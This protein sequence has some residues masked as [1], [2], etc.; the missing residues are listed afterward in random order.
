MLRCFVYCLTWLFQSTLHTHK[1][2]NVFHCWRFT[3]FFIK[4]HRQSLHFLTHERFAFCSANSIF[5]IFQPGIEYIFHTFSFNI[6]IS[7]TNH[8]IRFRVPHSSIRKWRNCASNLRPFLPRCASVLLF[9]IFV[10]REKER[11]SK[12][13]CCE[14]Q[15]LVTLTISINGEFEL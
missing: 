1:I 2:S 4:K 3:N 9:V 6:K 12:K 5:L 10:I 15:Q 8:Q 13:V 7:C 14:V 11:K